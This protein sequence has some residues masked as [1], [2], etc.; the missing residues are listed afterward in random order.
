MVLSACVPQ[1]LLTYNL[2]PFIFSRLHQRFT[3]PKRRQ[4]SASTIT[5]QS[6]SSQLC[7]Q[8]SDT[9][10][11]NIVEKL[12]ELLVEK[13]VTESLDHLDS[14]LRID[15]ENVSFEASKLREYVAECWE[16][17]VDGVLHG[18]NPERYQEF[19]GAMC[20]YIAD[21]MFLQ[22]QEQI[23]FDTIYVSPVSS[24]LCSYL[25]QDLP[26]FQFIQHLRVIN[27]NMTI[28]K[29]LNT[30]R[31]ILALKAIMVVIR[32]INGIR[33]GLSGKI[34]I[35]RGGPCKKFRDFQISTSPSP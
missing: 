8:L 35:Q 31:L 4:R 20:H 27:S 5:R 23:P 32:R 14:V 17:P 28:A 21:K 13:P 25:F 33:G 6:I 16:T 11:I 7:S 9:G 18:A 29:A 30:C 1:G 10:A 26:T 34:W 24:F 2:L 22:Q 19:V 3:K 15:E 12:K